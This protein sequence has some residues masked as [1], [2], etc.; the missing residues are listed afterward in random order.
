MGTAIDSL[1]TGV[2]I[3]RDAPILIGLSYAMVLGMFFLSLISI[4]IP[5]GNIV[6]SIG[7]IFALGGIFGTAFGALHEDGTATFDTFKEA[8]DENWMSIG[9]A[10]LIVAGLGMVLSFTFTIALTFGV[11]G[12][13]GAL[14]SNP[15]QMFA[16][17]SAVFIA[18]L[19]LFLFAMVAISLAIQ[20]YNVAIVVGGYSAVDS[21]KE[22]GAL[23]REAPMSVIGYSL[24]RGLITTVSYLIPLGIGA[25]LYQVDPMIGVVVGGLV[26]L[27]LFPLAITIDS[28]YHVAYYTA[29]RP[30]TLEESF[31]PWRRDQSPPGR[32]QQRQG[33]RSQEWGA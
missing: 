13:A 28:A 8:V 3:V 30:D 21:L 26:G 33:S 20:F 16:G 9:G 4:V 32:P 11:F 15:D 19:G 5:F 24:L 23:L 29:R 7:M 12:T 1:S 14:E 25:A 17:V 6:V 10:Y 2:D 27:V 18:I 31:P 22:S